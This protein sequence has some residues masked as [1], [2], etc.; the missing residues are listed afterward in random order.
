MN[1]YNLN[2]SVQYNDMIGTA[3]ADWQMSMTDIE[4][5]AKENGI[6]ITKYRPIGIK[7]DLAESKEG[8]LFPGFLSIIAVNNE[9]VGTTY[10][11]VK[12]Y[13]DT[14]GSLPVVVFH[15]NKNIFDLF[16]KLKRFCVSLISGYKDIDKYELASEIDLK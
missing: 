8:E 13:F 10:D 12:E 3:S 5:F 6:D 14:H 1:T 7:A 11:E 16:K 4:Y 9:V 15:I 2:A